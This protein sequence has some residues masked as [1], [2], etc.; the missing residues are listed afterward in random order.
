VYAAVKWKSRCALL[1]CLLPCAA[2]STGGWPEQPSWLP[3][4]KP[5]ILDVTCE[6]PRTFMGSAYIMLPTWDTQGDLTCAQ[7]AAARHSWWRACI[8]A[9]LPW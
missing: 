1:S 8:L 6:L 2:G 5:A 4:V 3:D 7:L 9:A